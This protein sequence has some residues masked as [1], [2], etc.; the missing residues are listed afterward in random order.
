MFVRLSANEFFTGLLAGL[1]HT[2]TR[3][4]SIRGDSFDL[5]VEAVARE[6][7]EKHGDEVELGFRVKPHYIHGDSAVVR[8]AI[9]SAAQADLISLD[10]PEYQ[11]IRLKIGPETADLILDELPVDRRIFLELADLFLLAY[12]RARPEEAATRLIA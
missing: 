5:A 4:I 8:D 7:V 3:R 9:A 6:L 12:D 10:N 11:D 2:G 1:A